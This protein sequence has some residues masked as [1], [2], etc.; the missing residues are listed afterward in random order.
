MAEEKET[1]TTTKKTSTKTTSKASTT[2]K[3]PA[4]T[5]TSAER[6]KKEALRR[7]VLDHYNRKQSLRP[8]PVVSDEVPQEVVEDFEPVMTE[9]YDY[10][11]TEEM[12]TAPVELATVPY[13]PT[14]TFVE[15]PTTFS[16]PTTPT[17]GTNPTTQ[18]PPDSK[19]KIKDPSRGKNARMLMSYLFSTKDGLFYVAGFVA[20]IAVIIM[21]IG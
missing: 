12:D 21:M 2:K 18:T 5:E 17:L 14:N 8:A 11:Y 20:L 10:D 6:E 19:I 16:A 7:E 1:K 15:E 3:A 9:D 13:T 4:K